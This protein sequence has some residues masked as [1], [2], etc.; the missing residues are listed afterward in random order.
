VKKYTVYTFAVCVRVGVWGH[1]KGGGA[2][3]R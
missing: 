3:A 1:R 2:S